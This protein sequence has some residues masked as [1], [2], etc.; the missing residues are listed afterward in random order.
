MLDHRKPGFAGFST[1]RADDVIPCLRCDTGPTSDSTTLD[2][3]Q[4]SCH[5]S[6]FEG[7]STSIKSFQRMRECFKGV[8]VSPTKHGVDLRISVAS[9]GRPSSRKV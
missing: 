1:F 5:S 9:L 6:N 8:I 7:N 4:V 3:S 2:G